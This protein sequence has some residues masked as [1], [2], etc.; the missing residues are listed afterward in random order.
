MLHVEQCARGRVLRVARG[1]GRVDG[2][3]G[4]QA[5]VWHEQEH[6]AVHAARRVVG[7]RCVVLCVW[8]GRQ[9]T[10]FEGRP[11]GLKGWWR[12][13]CMRVCTVCGG[14]ALGKVHLCRP[15][16]LIGKQAAS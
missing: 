6:T 13:P 16:G 10:C 14:A 8:M 4:A 9:G 15:L 12:G 7:E 3:G 11:W 5:H 1:A 2:R